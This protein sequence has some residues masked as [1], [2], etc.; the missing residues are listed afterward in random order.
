MAGYSGLL[1]RVGA[2]GANVA[3]RGRGKAGEPSASNAGSAED[4]SWA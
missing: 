3:V 1:E 4:W 2:A